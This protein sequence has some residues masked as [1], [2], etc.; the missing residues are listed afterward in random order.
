MADLRMAGKLANK[1]TIRFISKG[2]ILREILDSYPPADL[3][4]RIPNLF[5]NIRHTFRLLLVYTER[6]SS[7]CGKFGFIAMR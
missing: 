6:C 3:Q 2:P 1:A 5:R 7:F 4:F